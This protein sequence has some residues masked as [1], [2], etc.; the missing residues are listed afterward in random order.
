MDSERNVPGGARKKRLII[1]TAV[2]LALAFIVLI[3]SFM[4]LA[5][6][7]PNLTGKCVAVVDINMPLTV[8][9]QPMSL[10]ETGYP[11]SA[12]LA[13]TIDTLN[14]RED[15]GAVLFVFNSGGGSVVA[16]HEV[17]DAVKKVEKP[18]VSYFREVAASGAYYIATG[19]DYIVSDPDALTGSIG[20]VATVISMEGLFEKLGINATSVVSGAYKDMGSPYRNMSEGEYTIMKSVVDEIFDEFKTVI[21]QNR[22]ERLNRARFEEVI[23]GRIMTGR[24]ALEVGLVDEVGSKDDALMKAAALG[25]IEAESP[26]DIKICYVETLAQQGGLF[27]VE[28]LFGSLGERFQQASLR[29]Q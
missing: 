22:G 23:D 25:G 16:T 26:E 11:G 3:G 9:G 2:L 4:L 18:K 24:Q 28:S 29:F 14:K 13:N 27:G 7:L 10:F 17:Y 5:A 12:Q 6:F 21:I 15:V 8:E 20:V 19:T 1:G